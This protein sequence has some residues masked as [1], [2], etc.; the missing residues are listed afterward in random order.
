MKVYTRKGDSGDTG[1][2]GGTRVPKHHI[3]IE[4]YGSLDELN[5]FIGLLRDGVEDSDTRTLLLQ[6]QTELFTLGSHLATDPL[7]SSF[8]L[9]ELDLTLPTI[10]EEAMDQMTEGLPELKNF[11]LPGGHP[12]V[13]RAHICRTVTRRTERRVNEL[14]EMTAIPE[15]SLVLLNR[16]SD[17]FFVLARWLSSQTGS[18]EIAWKPA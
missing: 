11:I 4:A 18:E 12:L 1:L 15:A 9:P 13:S 2:I 5:S 3:R 7:K 16:L 10:L 8:K 17:Y 6:V 14:A